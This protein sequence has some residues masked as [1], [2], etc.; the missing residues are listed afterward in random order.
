M[1]WGS[2]SLQL[3]VKVATNHLFPRQVKTKY[4]LHLTVVASG[5]QYSR[6]SIFFFIFLWNFPNFPL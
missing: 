2:V 5:H 3:I 1:E 4:T 6:E